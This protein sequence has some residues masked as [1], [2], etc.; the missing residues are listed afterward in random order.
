LHFGYDARMEYQ[1]VIT[2]P[3]GK[4]GLRCSDTGLLGIDFLSARSTER[5]PRTALAREACRQLQTYLRDA[6]SVID[7]PFELSGTPHQCSVW[8]TLRNIPVGETRTYGELAAR[9]HSSPRAVGQACGSNPLPIVIPCH[10]VVGR[11]GLGGFMHRTESDALEI[12][13]WLLAHERR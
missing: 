3:F 1:A 11:Q 13:R 10:R 12:K 9:L 7:L 4:L 6:D 2:A 8:Q 5:A